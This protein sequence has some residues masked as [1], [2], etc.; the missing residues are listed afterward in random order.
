[1][2]LKYSKHSEQRSRNSYLHARLYRGHHS[3]HRAFAFHL[4]HRSHPA[5]SRADAKRGLPAL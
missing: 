5:D 2:P 1:M 4:C 3:R